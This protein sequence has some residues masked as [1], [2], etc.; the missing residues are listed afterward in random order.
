MNP[1]I[2]QVIVDNFHSNIPQNI[3]SNSEPETED[4]SQSNTEPIRIFK[5]LVK[6]IISNLINLKLF[7]THFFLNI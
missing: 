1:R 7:L 2:L 6:F 5:I 4:I 3:E